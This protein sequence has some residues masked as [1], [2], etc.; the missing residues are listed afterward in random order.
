MAG[1]ACARA[2][3]AA[4]REPLVLERSHAIGGRVRTDAVD[5]FLLDHGFQVL[6]TPTP[7]RGALLDLDRLDLGLFERGAIIRADGRFRRLA[8]PRH[9]PV[10]SLRALAGGRRR[11]ARRR[12]GAQAPARQ[13]RRDHDGRRAPARGRLARDGRDASSR[14]SCAGSSSRSGSRPRAASSTSSCARSPT[15]RRRC[16]P[17]GWARSRRSSRRAS[18]FARA[19]ASRPSGRTPSRS[20]RASSCGPSAVVVATAGHRR[21]AGA[22]VERR[23]RAST[24][25]R[26]RRPIPGPWLVVNGEGGPINNL[27]V[28]SEAA[29]SYAP[30]GRA[31]VSVTI[32]GAG[33]PDLEAGRAP[34]ARLVRLGRRR[35]APPADLPDPARAARLPGRRLRRAARAPRRRASTPAATTASIRR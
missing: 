26:P 15:G 18:R 32:L 31:L 6:P 4:G 2:L 19:P 30:P 24:S 3:A 33:E 5:G 21:R 8:D 14:R 29:P 9:A 34:A 35:L 22:R 23:S 13:R 20:S 17:A 27:C 7:R 25:T 16:R 10:R 28:P 12:G 11:R 1:L